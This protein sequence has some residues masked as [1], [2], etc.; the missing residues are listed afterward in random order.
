MIKH[1]PGF[2]DGR[3]GCPERTMMRHETYL[4]FKTAPFPCAA[5]TR[6]IAGSLLI[7]F[8]LKTCISDVH[9]EN[10][11]KVFLST[12]ICRGFTTL[13]SFKQENLQMLQQGKYFLAG[14]LA[15]W[16]GYKLATN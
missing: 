1:I 11:R 14:I 15:V 7:G 10:N 16:L 13:T 8:L 2:F 12:G 5:L 4:L 6:N 9:L 3:T